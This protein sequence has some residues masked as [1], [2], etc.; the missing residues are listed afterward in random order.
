MRRWPSCRRAGT[1][2][3]SAVFCMIRLPPASIP[4][5]IFLAAP[6]QVGSSDEEILAIA[7][8]EAPVERADQIETM[9]RDLALVLFC[10]EAASGTRH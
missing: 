4:G 8:R 6:S 10:A 9:M 2:I 7:R 3:V 5:G 1:E